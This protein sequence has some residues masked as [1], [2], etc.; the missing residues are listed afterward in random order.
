MTLNDYV[1]RTRSSLQD[2][3]PP[4]RYADQDIFDALNFVL[5]EIQRIRPD[6]FLD[7]KY[8]QPQQ[9]STDDFAPQIF[10]TRQNYNIKVPIPSKYFSPLIWYI[11]GYLQLYDVTDTQDQRAQAFLMKFQQHLLSVSA[12]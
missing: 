3:I 7:L 9:G 2:L 6:M 11:S 12:A 10:M 4:Y 5:F 1:N 8:Q